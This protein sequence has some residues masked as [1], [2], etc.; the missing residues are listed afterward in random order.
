M[1]SEI[2]YEVGIDRFLARFW[3]SNT[4]HDVSK[5]EDR[6]RLTERKKTPE[7]FRMHTEALAT[8]VRYECD[9]L[10]VGGGPAGL[11]AALAAAR[12]GAD[13]MII[14]RFGC[15][16]GKQINHKQITKLTNISNVF[17]INK[18]VWSPLLE[19]KL[20]VGID[21]R[22]QLI[23]RELAGSWNELLSILVVPE[24]GHST[25]APAL[26]QNTLKSFQT[27]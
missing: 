20:L 14:E 8:P 6:E 13:T 23:V 9:V 5:R 27:S 15:F 19:W 24:N 18:K 17:S 22:A 25:T 11:S 26:M 2:D 7:G 1:S 4:G 21:M 16:G 3:D 12:A 10:V